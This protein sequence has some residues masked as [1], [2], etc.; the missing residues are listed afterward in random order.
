MSNPDDK[1]PRSRAKSIVE[2]WNKRGWLSG[3][4]PQHIHPLDLDKLEELIAQE[5]EPTTA[6]RSASHRV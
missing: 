6:S 2:F 1:D 4:A 3:S 5:L